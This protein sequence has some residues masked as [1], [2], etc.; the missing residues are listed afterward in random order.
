MCVDKASPLKDP[1]D[2]SGKSIAVPS[3]GSLT[4]LAIEEWLLQNKADPAGVKYIELPFVQVAPALARGTVDAGYIGEPVLASTLGTATRAFGNPYAA[5]GPQVLICNWVTTRDWLAGNRD[6]ARRFVAAMTETARWANEHRELDGPDSR[7]VLEDRSGPD[8]GYAAGAVCNRFR[9]EDVTTESR[10][11]VQIQAD[12]SSGGG[13]RADGES[14][15][16]LE[17]NRKK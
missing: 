7:E 9:P 4:T 14:V 17:E 2:L 15:K 16:F 12:F 6:L 5:L 10:R 8:Q 13:R 11:R 3:L 1:R